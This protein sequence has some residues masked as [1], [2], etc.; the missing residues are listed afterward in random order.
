MNRSLRIAMLAHSTNPRGGVVHALHLS[1]ALADLGHEVV[2]HAPD[3]S[4]K[5]FF[6]AAGC[7]VRPFPVGPA[8]ADMTAMVI[9][10]IEDY[11]RHFEEKDV[12]GFDLYH[13][14]DGI[15]GNALATLKARGRI[16]GFMRTV[17]HVDNFADPHLNHLQARSI[18]EAAGLFTVS[19]HWRT[20]FAERGR[21]SVKVGNG[22]DMTR[23]SPDRDE[24]DLRLAGRLPRGAG[25]VFL[26]VGGVE[27]RKNTL[28]I[29]RAFAQVLAVRPDARLIIA[30][31]VSLLDH[32]TYQAAFSAELAARP[33]LAAA[34]TFLGGVA[35]EDMP[36]LFRSADALVF[37]SLMEGF[38]LVVLEAMA[39]G[40]P[41]VVS[42]VT[43]FTEYVPSDA[44][45]WCDPRR[46]SSIADA[47]LTVLSPRIRQ[48]CIEAGR[49]V[50]ARHDWR[51]VA[52]AHLPAYYAFTGSKE[53]AHA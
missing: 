49:R 19:D 39:S 29:L 35:D 47:M 31:G 8:P 40:L 21:D 36:A 37:P 44:A 26:A 34:V 27:R 10:R 15:S 1:E 5:G 41:V 23:F 18:D 11:V 38:G 3:A 30:G 52:M 14:H 46:A 13:A 24:S 45:V 53:M 16:S 33:H 2:L 6:R 25:P 17:H 7:G 12:S 51:S 4:G 48:G 20:W 28:G 43:P 42:S 50:A 9:R 22:V 32:R